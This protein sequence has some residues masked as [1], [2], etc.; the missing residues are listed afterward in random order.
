MIKAYKKESIDTYLCVGDVVGYGADPNECIEKT[1]ALAKITVAGNHDWAAVGLF[2][3]EYFNPLAAEA[4]L[5][6]KRKLSD[7]DRT[8]LQSLELVYENDDLTLVHGTLDT[9]HDFNYMEDDYAA[10]QSFEWLKNNICFVGHSHVAGIFV[11]EK[12][13]EISYS[14][15]SSI[16]LAPGKKYIVNVGSIGQPRDGNPKAAY[17]VYDSAKSEVSIKRIDYDV[18]AARKKILSAGLPEFLGERLL[19]GM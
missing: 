18:E 5:W 14:R 12:G 3:K 11:L 1:K 7:S 13:T 4:I 8:F 2:S 16:R 10:G 9:P 15:D 6:T 17:C 19:T